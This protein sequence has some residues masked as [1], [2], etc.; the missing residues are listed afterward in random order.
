MKAAD[1]P[2]RR[3]KQMVPVEPYEQSRSQLSEQSQSY[4]RWM[5]GE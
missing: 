3:Y 4:L 1:S 5:K 2:I